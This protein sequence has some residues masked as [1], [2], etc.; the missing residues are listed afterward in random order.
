MVH[1]LSDE[2]LFPHPDYAN[3]EGLLAV[4]GDLSAERLL[5]AY[6]KGIFPWFNANDPPLWWSPNPRFVLFPDQIRITKSMR[7]IL[8]KEQFEVTFDQDFD[9]VIKACGETPRDGQGGTWIT[10]NMLRAY[11]KLYQLGYAHSVEVWQDG[12]LAGGLYGVS[13]G[14]CFFG[15]SMFTWVSNASKTALMTLNKVLIERGFWLIDCQMYTQHLERLGAAGIPRKR[16]L[17]YLQRNEQ[18]PT[19]KG[20]WAEWRIATSKVLEGYVHKK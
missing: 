2:L 8:R 1:L 13:I 10:P 20:S 12:E 11:R 3:E 16:F 18:E 15:E 19:H 7:R 14:K 4:G 17:D 5:L 6:R 9:R